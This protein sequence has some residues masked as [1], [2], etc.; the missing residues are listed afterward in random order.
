MTVDIAALKDAQNRGLVR[1]VIPTSGP[2]PLRLEIDDFISQDPE[3]ANLFFG[4]FH[5]S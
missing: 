4:S 2:P 5:E 1:G 3:L